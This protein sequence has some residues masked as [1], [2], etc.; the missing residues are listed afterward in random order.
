MRIR[1]ARIIHLESARILSQQL[2]VKRFKDTFFDRLNKAA[3]I[4]CTFTKVFKD[5]PG[6]YGVGARLDNGQPSF[7]SQSRF[8]IEVSAAFIYDIM[9]IIKKVEG[10]FRP[11]WITLN[12]NQFPT[13]LIR[14]RGAATKC[15][16]KMFC[17]ES[18][19]L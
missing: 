10:S 19:R 15:S 11:K 12:F 1:V 2:R 13:P 9:A 16:Q 6:Q 17:D 4:S 8:P 3:S 18:S 14:P 5:L 7:R